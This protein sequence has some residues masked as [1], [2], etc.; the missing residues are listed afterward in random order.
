MDEEED[1]KK[2][3]EVGESALVCN[4]EFLGLTKPTVNEIREN[5][6]WLRLERKNKF[7]RE[8]G[9][10]SRL[11][12]A[13]LEN[14]GSQTGRG[15]RLAMHAVTDSL[16]R[17]HNSAHSIDNVMRQNDGDEDQAK[18]ASTNIVIIRSMVER[19]LVNHS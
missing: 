1:G 14:V 16:S 7:R 11:S 6:V 9:E 19:G 17:T 8:D 3:K 15:K 10:E 5:S 12:L 13:N 18:C 4:L 2:K